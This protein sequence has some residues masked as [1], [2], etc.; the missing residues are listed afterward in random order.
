MVG[1]VGQH[2]CADRRVQVEGSI[3]Y[4]DNPGEQIGDQTVSIAILETRSWKRGRKFPEIFK[5]EITQDDEFCAR[6]AILEI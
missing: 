5:V 2:R 1:D 6:D 3:G 4:L